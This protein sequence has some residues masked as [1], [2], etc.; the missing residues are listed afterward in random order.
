MELE[1]I[2]EISEEGLYRFVLPIQ[3]HSC[4][5]SQSENFTPPSAEFAAKHRVDY[6]DEYH[7][8]DGPSTPLFILCFL[9]LTVSRPP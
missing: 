7:G 5:L 8:R 4:P 3:G 9:E 6:T 2:L 1:G